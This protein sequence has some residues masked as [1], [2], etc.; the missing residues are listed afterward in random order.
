MALTTTGTLVRM[1]W[2][3]TGVAGVPYYS[4]LCLE[5]GSDDI[6]PEANV[7]DAFLTG[8][9]AYFVDDMAWNFPTS[10]PIFDVA[11][12]EAT[13]IA[14]S[15]AESGNGTATDEALPW[16]TQIHVV[17][18]TGEYVNGRELR[19]GLFLPGLSQTVNDNG[20]LHPGN[21]ADLSGRLN[22]WL[23]DGDNLNHEAVVYSPTHRGYAAITS[24]T[25]TNQ[26]AV[27]RSRRT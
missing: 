2:T 6:T 22:D 23:F 18:H 17:F 25:V 8:I 11:T 4:G 5:A 15:D 10:H 7:T 24:A 9:G 3:W 12:G 14:T 13:G 21:V 16:A 19:G 20:V 1:K 27:L 26:F